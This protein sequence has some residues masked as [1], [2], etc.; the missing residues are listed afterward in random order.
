MQPIL[1]VERL[2]TYLRDNH[3]RLTIILISV[4]GVL[5][6]LLFYRNLGFHRDELLYFSLGEHPDFGYFSVP[7]LIGLLAALLTKLFGYTLFAA[8]ILP[9]L[10]GGVLVYLCAMLTRELK[11]GLFAQILAAVGVICSILFL[12]AFSLF[13]PVF[14]D[15]FFWTLA[16]YFLLS[17]HNS[18]LKKYLY[19]FGLTVG[20]GILNKFNL[21]FLVIAVI[22]ILPFTKH[23]KLFLCRDF[24]LTILLA[25]LIV[26]PN[27]IWQ[28]AHQF[29][30]L[31]HLS[32]LQ[33]SQL[34]KM[35]SATF[36]VEQLLMNY[37]A[38]ILVLPG[39]LFLLFNKRAKEY[40][41]VGYVLVLVL[42]LYLILQGKSYYSAGIYPMLVAAGAVFFERYIRNY[43]ARSFIMLV[44]LLLAWLVLPMGVP[45][46]SPEKLVA[47]FDAM[48]KVTHNDAVRRYENNKYF[49][50]PQDY[51]DMLG[52]DELTE[53]T[54]KAWQQTE[55][56][57]RCII[58]AQNY[59]QAGAIT[60]L[61]KKYHLP[62]A[63]SFSDNFRYRI[64]KTFDHE[65]TQFI[66][67]NNELGK[68][69]ESLF[70]DIQEI[71]R[72]TNPLA[73]EFGTRVYLCQ[74]PRT[75]FNQFWKLRIQ[76]L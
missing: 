76:N 69:V 71:G 17:Y 35:S 10:L 34:T 58:Y 53:I 8:K 28:I 24:Y 2:K 9:A 13:Q 36:L 75:S 64:P 65:I 42:V 67:I 15:I 3:N 48:A 41:W 60:V 59:G 52:W 74:K 40:H 49:Q 23:R 19:L 30:V 44:L 31:S 62:E 66:Y 57:G 68:D 45:S 73:R 50:L 56:D 55:P 6:H 37:P 4:L 22:A 16:L 38:T 20:I 63:I 29:P 51:A 7:P 18:N 5:I 47:Y 70:Q 11:G 25:F 1:R 72:I 61:G 14:L 27:I 54:N 32:Q 26:L 39:L 21:L 43:M 46:K 33:N 12:R